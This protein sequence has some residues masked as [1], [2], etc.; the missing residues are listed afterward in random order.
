MPKLTW[1]QSED[2]GIALY[3]KFPD[4]DPTYVRYT[5]LHQWVTELEDFKDDPK[6]STEGKLEAIQMAW[7]EEYQSDH[8]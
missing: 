7:I 8:S 1:D 5:D 6:G 4:L 2:I 3:E